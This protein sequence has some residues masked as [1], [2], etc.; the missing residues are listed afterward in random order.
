MNS[1]WLRE[2]DD[3]KREGDRRN[4]SVSRNRIWDEVNNGRSRKTI[5]SLLGFNLKRGS[6]SL[7]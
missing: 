2:E 3:D 1:I 6:L 4:N 5:D 7:D